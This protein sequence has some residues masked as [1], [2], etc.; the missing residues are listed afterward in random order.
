MSTS[1]FF[2]DE[3][4]VRAHGVKTTTSAFV[5]EIAREKSR[6]YLSIMKYEKYRERPL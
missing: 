1:T 3:H 4:F 6:D 5:Y 2:K